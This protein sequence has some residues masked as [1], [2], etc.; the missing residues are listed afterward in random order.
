MRMEL[1]GFNR[2]EILR[3]SPEV[4]CVVARNKTRTAR[5]LIAENPPPTDEMN[6][7]N[8]LY[9]LSDLADCACTPYKKCARHEAW[10]RNS[11]NLIPAFRGFGS[12]WGVIE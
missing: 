11:Q 6:I 1:V 12:T 8:A 9:T 7:Q 4:L 10:Y 3:M 2:A 5:V